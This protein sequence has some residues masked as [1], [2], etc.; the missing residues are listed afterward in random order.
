MEGILIG[1]ALIYLFGVLDD[2]KDF[3]PKLKF[4]GQVICACIVYASGIRLDFIANFL[5]GNDLMFGSIA[6]FL[7]TVLWTLR[8]S[9]GISMA[10]I[11]GASQMASGVKAAA[12]TKAVRNDIHNAK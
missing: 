12:S 6:S 3:S 2:L 8:S 9:F 1:G 11:L 4:L 10:P 7:V 5:G